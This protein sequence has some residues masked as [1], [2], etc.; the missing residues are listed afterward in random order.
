MTP[1]SD[2]LSFEN[3]QIAFSYKSNNELRRSNLIFTFI[4]SNRFVQFGGW[5]TPILLKLRMPITGIIRATVFKQFCAGESLEQSAAT[6]NKLARYEVGT[7]LDYG[8]EAKETDEEFEKAVREFIRAIEF[9]KRNSHVP[10]ISVKITGLARFALLEKLNENKKLEENEIQ[11]WQ[12]VM[13]RL[14]RICK[15]ANDGGIGVMLDAEETWIQKPLDEVATEMMKFYNRHRATVFNTFQLYRTDR[16]EYLQEMHAYSRKEKFVLGIKLVRG[17]YMEKERER[18]EKMG[19]VSPIQPNK[20]SCDD[21]FNKAVEY[22]LNNIESLSVCVASHNEKSNLIATELV[23]KIGINHNHQNLHFSQLYGMSD[24]LTFNLA[25]A[26]FNVSKY[27]PYGPVRDV[28]PYLLR[29]AKENTS[30][31]GQTGRELALIKKEMKRRVI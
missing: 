18:A 3:T 16:L 2:T 6:I 19:Y 21:D 24:N 1:V 4:N 12:K 26:G 31:A 9:A 22:C 27:I 25:D 7:I 28:V 29:R 30:V 13:N 11:E 10:F 20:E 17:A 15:A 5:I 14:H 8:V 23:D